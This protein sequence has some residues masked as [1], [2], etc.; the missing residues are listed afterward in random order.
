MGAEQPATV[1]GRRAVIRGEL[2]Q[3]LHT[4]HEQREQQQQ[5]D[6]QVRSLA[7]DAFLADER[8]VH[9]RLRSEAKWFAAALCSALLVAA[10]AKWE[11]WWPGDEVEGA[12]S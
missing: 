12:A 9:R 1:A 5:Y 6:E 2:K 3:R 7:Q 8:E 4:Q 10:F 11:G